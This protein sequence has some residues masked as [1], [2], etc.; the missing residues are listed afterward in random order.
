MTRSR[1]FVPLDPNRLSAD[2]KVIADRLLAGPRGKLG[3]TWRAILHNPGIAAPI[4]ALGEH[5]RYHAVLPLALIELQ[6]LVMS[7]DRNMRYLCDVHTPIAL[8]V[9]LAQTI[10]DTV[11]AGRKPD[12]MTAD[13]ALV[14]RFAKRASR[15]PAIDKRIAEAVVGRFG[16]AGF[17]ELV[18]VAAYYY[19]MFA[20]LELTLTPEQRFPTE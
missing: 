14:Y 8:K 15:N 10:I 19:V 7:R 11:V 2:Q 3:P 13:E 5:V 4:E 16:E 18:G 9:G 1:P 12:G 6:I 20:G 17:I